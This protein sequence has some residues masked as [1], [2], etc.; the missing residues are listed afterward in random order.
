VSI[1]AELTQERIRHTTQSS[2][3]PLQ[4]CGLLADD[5]ERGAVRVAD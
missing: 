1:L 5:L 3:H 4:E 2:T